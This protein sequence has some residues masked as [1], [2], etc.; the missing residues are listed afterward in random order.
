MSDMMESAE[1]S[2]TSQ[3]V[4]GAIIE[5]YGEKALRW[6]QIAARNELAAR[7]CDGFTRI[8]I[9]LPTGAG[10]TLT[11][12]CSMSDSS[13]RKALGVFDDR[14]LRILFASHK[15][16]L[17][18]QAERTF[19]E[20]SNVEII[21][22]SIFSDIPPDVLKRG[23]DVTILDECHHEYC[24]SFQLQLERIGERPIIGLTATSDRADGGLIKFETFIR[25]ISREQAVAE[26]WLAETE[27]NSFVDTPAK[28]K[29][30]F[31]KEIID[32]FGHEMGQTMIFVRTKKEVRDV[33]N[34]LNAKGYNSIAILEQ[35]EQELDTLLNDFSKGV[36]QFLVNCNKI[37]E[38]VDCI[39]V[40]DVF[41][42]RQFGSYPQLN[43]VIGR[44]SRPDSECRVWELIN[45]LSGR[46]LDTTAVV[47]TPK[48]HRLIFK[49]GGRWDE[50]EFG[51]SSGGH[52]GRAMDEGV[53][54]SRFQR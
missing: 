15:H 6:Y 13:V 25:P 12:A 30:P 28:D 3:A 37:N 43:Q 16:R 33:S 52:A 7:L 54:K 34:Y 26:G 23:W 27:L 4:N 42:G 50:R 46:N 44:A 24:M 29:T 47:G 39:G 11:I 20:E 5:M 9:E 10:K 35:S 40:S 49:S 48:R 22:H 17:L 51:Y 36:H 18:T 21:T 1:V 32:N 41:L 14:P 45:P 38:G 19:T 31:I 53:C 2:E 8:C